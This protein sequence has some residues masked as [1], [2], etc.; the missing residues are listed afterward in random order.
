MRG[1]VAG[2]YVG[3][4]AG[5]TWSTSVDGYKKGKSRCNYLILPAC[6]RSKLGGVRGQGRSNGLLLIRRIHPKPHWAKS[7]RCIHGQLGTHGIKMVNRS[8]HRSKATRELVRGTQ[9]MVVAT[10]SSTGGGPHHLCRV[11]CGPISTKAVDHRI[12]FVRVSKCLT[13]A[14]TTEPVS[15]GRL[16][17]RRLEGI[18][19]EISL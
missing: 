4:S 12:G 18:V 8:G 2:R 3:P 5:T 10:A 13:E 7:R 17:G 16:T 14:S 19:G 11:L 15:G 9:S 1:S 6:F